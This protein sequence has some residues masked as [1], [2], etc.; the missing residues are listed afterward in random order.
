MTWLPPNEPDLMA[1]MSSTAVDTRDGLHAQ[2]LAKLLWVHHNA[3]QYQPSFAAVRLSFALYYWGN[4]AAVYPPARDA[5]VRTRDEAESAFRADRGSFALFQELAALNAQLGEVSRT[6]DLFV[7]TAQ[8]DHTVARRLY[9]AAEPCLIATGRYDACGPFI[10]PSQRLGLAVH[11]YEMMSE[12]E[13]EEPEDE[14]RPPKTARRIFINDVATLVGV[15]VL[16]QRTKEAGRART[17][18]LTVLDD[19]EF[20][21]LLDAAMSGHLPPSV[22]A[23]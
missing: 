19:S 12:T 16:N 14:L 20:R 3:L 7:D 17:Q 4:L 22:V 1:I 6:A 23:G 10:N 2:A 8:R 5:L 18:A 11:T 15:L 9:H 21:E 13:E